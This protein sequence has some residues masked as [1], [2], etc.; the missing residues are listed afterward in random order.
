MRKTIL[1]NDS[2]RCQF[3]NRF[4]IASKRC[5]SVK[6]LSWCVPGAN[7]QQKQKLGN[8]SSYLNRAVQDK[9][10]S[11]DTTKLP[12]NSFGIIAAVSK[13]RIIG[14][15]GKLPWSVPQDREYFEQ[16]TN[17]KVLIMG[18]T[19][20]VV[21]SNYGADIKHARSCIVV[22]KTL[23][24][25]GLPISQQYELESTHFVSSFADALALAQELEFDQDKDKTAD[26]DNKTENISTSD[27]DCWIAGGERIY[28][29]AFRHKSAQELHLTRID[30]QVNVDNENEKNVARFPA[31]YR[32]DNTFKLK[33]DWKGEENTNED[34]PSCHFYVYERKRRKP[35]N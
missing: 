8:A 21:D 16:I 17:Q 19:T 25:E 33:K 31:N 30:I 5:L 13:N 4:N 6:E 22:S 23:V 9:L 14:I 11:T 10:D 20:F 2:F 12:V 29:E 15:N 18:K 24:E 35:N 26:Q 7:M 34:L 1:T 27:L 28:E 32:W 3:S